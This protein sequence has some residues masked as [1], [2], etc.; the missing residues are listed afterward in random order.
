MKKFLLFVMILVLGGEV[1][2]QNRSVPLVP[3]SFS[4]VYSAPVVNDDEGLVFPSVGYRNGNLFSLKDLL[5]VVGS[6]VNL[7]W[8]LTNTGHYIR[9]RI[10]LQGTNVFTNDID[11]F[12]SDLNQWLYTTITVNP[13]FSYSVLTYSDGYSSGN[14]IDS[15]TG[16]IADV[17]QQEILQKTS[18]QFYFWD[19]Y[20]ESAY[21]TLGALEVPD[22]NGIQYAE[23]NNLDFEGGVLPSEITVGGSA[24]VVTGG[25]GSDFAFYMQ[26]N[27]SASDYL[28]FA[29]NGAEMITFD[30]KLN[31]S[32]SF[33][34][35]T[36]V[37][38][39]NVHALSVYD[40]GS[41]RYEA[42]WCEV[43]LPIATAS[44]IR[45]EF[46]SSD[47]QDLYLDNVRFYAEESFQTSL[48]MEDVMLSEN[49]SI[50]TVVGT[51]S[52]VNTTGVDYQLEVSDITA[53]DNGL[54]AFAGDDLEVQN[55]A[56]Y[57][58][59]GAGFPNVLAF[60]DTED[61]LPL[62]F[63]IFPVTINDEDE[64]PVVEA[65]QVFDFDEKSNVGTVI[66]S[67]IASD[68]DAED[69]FTFSL[70]SGNDDGFFT[71]DSSTG[72]L[73][74][75]D[76]LIE[77]ADYT[78]FSLVVR[79]TDADNELLYDEETI[80]LN[81]NDVAFSG[82][83][84][85]EA[86]PFRIKTPGD[87]DD[88][89][90]YLG[91]THRDKHYEFQNDI[92]LQDYLST[93][94]PGYNE[95]AFWEPIGTDFSTSFR[96]TLNGNGYSVI[97]LK[98]NR[99]VANYVGLFGFIYS[100]S[101]FNLSINVAEDG[102]ISGNQYVGVLSGYADSNQLSGLHV[103]G[104]VQG[105]S[106]F[107]GGLS[108]V[109]Y[110]SDLENSA[111]DVV[112][113]SAGN[114]VGGM[115]GYSMSSIQNCSVQGTISGAQY[116]GGIVGNNNNDP[117]M[118]S[119][120]LIRCFSN[121]A[122][123]AVTGNAGGLTGYNLGFLSYSYA[124]GSINAP[125]K[126]GGAVGENA[127]NEIDMGGG[128]IE[129]VS[130]TITNCYSATSVNG[131]DA[132]IGGFAGAND[133]DI[134]STF[135]DINASGQ[136]TSAGGT[137]LNGIEMR[138]S[139][140]FTDWDFTNI[141]GIDALE[142]YASY[143]YLIANEE[144]PHPGAIGKV[145]VTS[146]P[147]ASDIFYG[148]SVGESL[149]TGGVAIHEGSPVAGTFSLLL[150]DNNH[151]VGTFE[152]QAA[153]FP[154]DA[155]A[156]LP[157]VD[158]TVSVSVLPKPVSVVNAIAQ[159]KSYD[160]TT[161]AV[162]SGAELEENAVE[163]N[164]EVLLGNYMSGAFSQSGAGELI[165]VITN[166]TL[167]GADAS[168][169][170]LEQPVLSASISKALLTVTADDQTRLYGEENPELTVSYSGFVNGEDASVLTTLPAVS[171]DA[172]AENN[173]NNYAITVGGGADENY[174]FS[175]LNGILSVNQAPLTVKARDATRIVGQPNPVFELEFSGFKNGEDVEVIDEVPLATCS[176]DDLSEP[177]DYDILV[178]GGADQNYHFVYDPVPG[179]LTVT[180]ATVLMQESVNDIS[181][182]PLP[183]VHFVYVR[184][185]SVSDVKKLVIFDMTGAEVYVPYVKVAA[186][187][188]RID[189][190][191]FRSGVYILNIQQDEEIVLKKIVIL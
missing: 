37:D 73:A 67:V 2:S 110:F 171:S 99:P 51:A 172:G 80:N 77:Y 55:A 165:D 91:S 62:A 140:S 84:G 118:G 74:V 48:S 95:G 151:D 159:D 47:G 124:R 29:T 128:W 72:E 21:L 98:I 188:L 115:V 147:E 130:G 43:A 3:E 154:D 177:G 168:K 12:V 186:D 185:V 142:E 157:V 131:S 183:A 152:E 53:G 78:Q 90:N 120:S 40:Q 160:G 35:M 139:V 70:V 36:I 178:S 6:E 64:A 38:G 117:M 161:D 93:G 112:V 100:S 135:W 181:V 68:E 7:K 129:T 1:Y 105:N 23:F 122:V 9:G 101:I 59:D 162:I 173:V 103:S 175:Y 107:V 137:G 141:W 182:Y 33:R 31:H 134:T 75:A 27:A 184:G 81:V 56:D 22:H 11:G 19:T 30:V 61:F 179:V 60:M 136:E 189:V 83:A 65:G 190:S 119:G 144:N 63:T 169:Y 138:E 88:I 109:L 180:T 5:N 114:Y 104:S 155:G 126:A 76:G 58:T 108:S 13:D 45:I 113:A 8:K 176:A 158:G 46:W 4:T 163:G 145:T 148:Q 170:S 32:N 41:T 156:Y 94:N 42:D 16:T 10:G 86:D 132:T 69:N 50:G 39:I 102:S 116:V 92:D 121:A 34:I 191:K 87:L 15:N 85:T 127:Y 167:T 54:F 18:I 20:D 25:A 44:T 149:L 89:R 49:S 82:G 146:W 123:N 150:V 166:M 28:E 97:N 71:L 143:P 111:A 106:D 66:G 52:V 79:A 187:L 14:L 24:S 17:T 164:D 174:D 57:E 125:F 153:F 133:G 26:G 96:G